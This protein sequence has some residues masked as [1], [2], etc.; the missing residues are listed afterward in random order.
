MPIVQAASGSSADIKRKPGL[1]L[2]PEL[3][4][5]A[6][7]RVCYISMISAVSTV[8]FCVLQ[9]LFQPEAK[10]VLRNP[11]VRLTELSLLLMS[12]GFLALQRS[13]WLSQQTILYLGAVY[14]VLVAFAIA[15]MESFM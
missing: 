13:G 14:Q 7:T 9:A 12:V 15:L 11:L 4:E 10:E 6:V 1:R 2:P 5:K 8:M 3:L